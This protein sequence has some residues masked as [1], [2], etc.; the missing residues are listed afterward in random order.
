MTYTLIAHTELGS[1]QA[2]INF[3]SIPATF[4]DLLVLTSTR[5]ERAG[6]GDG[7]RLRLGN[8]GIDTGANYSSRF[9]QGFDGSVGSFTGP[10]DR[11]SGMFTTGSGAT[12]NTFGNAAIYIANYRSSVAKSVSLDSVSETNGT[13]AGQLISAGLWN[14]TSVVTNIRLFNDIGS[15]FVQYSSATL[16]GIT[17]GTSGGVVVS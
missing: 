9:L 10:T 12:A 17:A 3:T 5:S 11:I 15:N 8:S 13:A 16:Y 6:T 1:A 7:L 4:T 2:E 14:S